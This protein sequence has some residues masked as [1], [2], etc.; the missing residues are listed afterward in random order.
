MNKS[1][2][3]YILGHVFLLTSCL[4]GLLP[5]LVGLIYLEHEAVA[6]LIVASACFL[7]GFIMTRNKPENT[8]L[9]LKEGCIST[10]LAWIL[11]SLIGCLPFF[12]TGEIPS[13][14]DAL[15]ETISGFTTTGASILANVEGLSHCSLLWRSFTHWIGGM[16]VLVFLGSP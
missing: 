2:I 7:S 12:V 14:T 16:G 6:Y 8:T 15:F 5:A 9:Y 10:S 4:M 3:R 11:L 1:I 13:F